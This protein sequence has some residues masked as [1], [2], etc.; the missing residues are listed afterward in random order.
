MKILI[1]PAKKMRTD[2]DTLS[3][4]AL[5]AF[6]PE[7]E[8]LLS[9]LRSLSR[10]EL[11]QLWRC[12]DAITDLNVERLARMELGK[13]L[14]P[15]LLSYQGIQYQYMAPGVFETG[16]FTYL[17]EHLRILS[18]FYGMLHPFDGV[19]PYRLEMQARL[20]VNGCPDLYAF[21][22]DRLARA[23]AGEAGL[24]V[25]LASQEY[26]RAVL[27]HL[28]PSVEVLTCTF[29]ELRKDGRVVEK[30]TLC[31]MARGQMVRWM[32]ERGV[33]RSEEL[34]DFQDLGYRYDA[35]H[36]GH[37]HYVFLKEKEEF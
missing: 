3:P 17:Q 11:K 6:L 7:T 18:G 16:Q 9:A 34:K 26:S 8:R 32:A 21:W 19:T 30:G 35:A 27:P 29:G 15:A 23:L 22:G 12:S 2:T 4:Q 20:S 31:K 10:Q 24:V 28:P 36:S 5:P 37:D 14:T 1:S 25:D 13:G 33:H